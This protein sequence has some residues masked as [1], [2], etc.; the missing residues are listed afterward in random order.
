MPSYKVLEEEIDKILGGFF[1]KL[2]AKFNS[3]F[4]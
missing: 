3:L 4:E 2:G 1:S